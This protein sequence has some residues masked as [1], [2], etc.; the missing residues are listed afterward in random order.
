VRHYTTKGTKVADIAWCSEQRFKLIE[1]EAECSIAPELCIEIISSS[2][3]KNEMEEKK[4]LYL[5]AGAI[6]FWACNEEGE[7]KFFDADGPL[8]NSNL[9]PTF[10]DI[11]SIIA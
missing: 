4:Q 8:N 6:E 3:T 2:Y 5:S 7:V 9:V 10:P 11:I 1:H